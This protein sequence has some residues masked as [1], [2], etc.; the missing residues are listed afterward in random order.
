MELN[1]KDILTMIKNVIE[2]EHKVNRE[3]VTRTAFLYRDLGLD[4]FDRLE[5]CVWAE[6]T[7]N[8]S[9]DVDDVSTVGDLINLITKKI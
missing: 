8:L 7:F 5:L 1:E 9:I 6:T 2:K 3:A 4:S